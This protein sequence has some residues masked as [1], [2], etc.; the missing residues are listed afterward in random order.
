MQN[1]RL[2]SAQ[3]SQPRA[4]NQVIE[5][6]S[7]DTEGSDVSYE[8][9]FDEQLEQE[10]DQSIENYKILVLQQKAIVQ[11]K[12]QM[13]RLFQLNPNVDHI[14]LEKANFEDEEELKRLFPPKYE[15]QL[16]NRKSTIGLGLRG[17]PQK[18][19]RAQSQPQ[20]RIDPQWNLLSKNILNSS[21]KVGTMP[22]IEEFQQRINLFRSNEQRTDIIDLI[23]QEQ[24]R[25]Q[26]DIQMQDKRNK[27]VENAVHESIEAKV[28]KETGDVGYVS[29]R[30]KIQFQ[31]RIR[32]AEELAQEKVEKQQKKKETDMLK[33]KRIFEQLFKESDEDG[34]FKSQA[35]EELYKKIKKCQD[36][37]EIKQ[38][39]L[40]FIIQHR[41]KQ[42]EEY[43]NKPSLLK[44]TRF[45]S[46]DNK[47]FT[48]LIT[49]YA[50]QIIDELDDFL[51]SRE[52]L[53][54]NNI[55][56]LTKV[57]QILEG[58]LMKVWKQKQTSKV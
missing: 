17:V 38:T 30:K 1:Q 9:S 20:S 26:K 52:D 36:D 57:N 28:R 10:Y 51:D 22:S 18:S 56:L 16:I 46:E 58:N 32:K 44:P 3:Q 23:I 33:S 29:F 21:K 15:Q 4:I 39:I 2:S 27:A 55:Y 35:V 50:I 7:D 8:S 6:N 37:A 24:D 25:L 14:Q 34:E 48:L 13:E 41:K 12:D 42:I 11:F 53:E 45:I 49:K 5:L 31:F 43:Q 54:D 47:E 40:Q 19:P